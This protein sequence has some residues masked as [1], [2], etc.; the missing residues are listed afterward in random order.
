VQRS[1]PSHTRVPLLTVSMVDGIV[2]I[3]PH[4]DFDH[5][6]L[7]ATGAVL[8]SVAAA[9][10]CGETVMIDLGDGNDARTGAHDPFTPTEWPHSLDDDLEHVEGDAA[11]LNARPV[12]PGC[13]RLGAAHETWTLDVGRRRFCRSAGPVDPKFV[14]A[15]SWTPIAAIWVT[16]GRSTL[17]MANGMY[18]SAPTRWA[19]MA[20]DLQRE[21]A[22][23]A[24]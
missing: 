8:N 14:C 1:D 24:A 16:A 19:A 20:A 2:V 21:R 5:I 4:V 11:V 23:V 10:A 3:R 13:I 12:A 18:V 7:H 6:D 17:L 9:V 22:I 15:D